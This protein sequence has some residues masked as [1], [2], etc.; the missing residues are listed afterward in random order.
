[1]KPVI[2]V[3]LCVVICACTWGACGTDEGDAGSV[4]CTIA[5]L[6][7]GDVVSD[8][9]TVLIEVSDAVTL[10]ELY[11]DGV[12]V[13]AGDVQ[14]SD[15]GDIE[16]TWDTSQADDGAVA[17]VAHAYNASG[18]EAD[19]APVE[20]VVDNTAPIISFGVERLTLVEGEA[21]VPLS[22]DEANLSTI[23]VSDQFG[24]LFSATESAE[25]FTWDTTTINDGV[26]WLHLEVT[27]VAGATSQIVGH[28][29]VVA[30]HGQE[31]AV[32]YA[33]DATASVPTDYA[34][35]E[36]HTRATAAMEDGVVR[37]LTWLTWDVQEDWLME[38]TVGQGICPHRGIPYV[39]QESREGEI[40]IDLARADLPADI[41]SQFPAAD[42]AGTTF[43]NDGDPATFG[44]LFGHVD[45]LEPADH[46][47]ESID[48]EVHTVFFY[49][50]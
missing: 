36:Y 34:T 8:S 16:L 41:V 24:V 5:G 43:P 11:A 22:I 31:V 38:L 40:V 25:S 20:L 13:A 44:S 30:N 42:Q 33:P 19:S 27:D 48:I 50:D 10:V 37:V 32:V 15:A 6:A 23:R 35:T 4:Q 21:T 17:L 29:L 39:R 3:L 9:I 26:Y 18:T 28:P 47:G 49:E 14:D 1:M 2:F 46:V 45:P 12:E 7:P